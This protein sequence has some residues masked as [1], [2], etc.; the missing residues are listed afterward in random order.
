MCTHHAHEPTPG[1][2]WS[3]R[4]MQ[5]REPFEKEAWKIPLLWGRQDQAAATMQERVRNASLSRSTPGI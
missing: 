4:E 1:R 2:V 5:N 3:R